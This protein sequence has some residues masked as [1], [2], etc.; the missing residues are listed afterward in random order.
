MFISM[1]GWKIGSGR[2]DAHFSI[3]N[4]AIIHNHQ[5]RY[6]LIGKEFDPYHADRLL[7]DPLYEYPEN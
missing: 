6:L 3:K 5:V 1:F 4:V 7:M 2:V